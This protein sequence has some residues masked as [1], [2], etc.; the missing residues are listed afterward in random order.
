M[1]G[2]GKREREREKGVVAAMERAHYTL[3]IT[4]KDEAACTR[5]HA[6]LDS[7]LVV[8]TAREA[9]PRRAEL[10]HLHDHNALISAA[11]GLLLM[12]LARS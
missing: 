10:V 9:R 2:K 1:T 12:L 5:I 7:A 6:I 4:M 11:P 8:A 3:T